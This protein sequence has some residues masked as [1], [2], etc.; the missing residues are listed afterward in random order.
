MDIT[1]K[2]YTDT[3]DIVSPNVDA[4]KIDQSFKDRYQL[5][6]FDVNLVKQ[7]VVTNTGMTDYQCKH[8]VAKSQ[9]TPWKQVRQSLMEL[10]VRYHSYQ[11][12]RASLR[13]SEIT[14]KKML[15]QIEAEADPLDKELIQID[16]EKLD[17]DITIYK[18][19]FLQSEVEIKAFIDVIKQY[20]KDE[21]DLEYYTKDNPEEERNYW[22]ARMGK[23]A[24][25]DIIAFGRVGS[26][27][28]DSIAMMGEEDQL[29]ALTMAVQYS[30]LV[31]AGLHKISNV[32]QS[33]IDQYLNSPSTNIAAVMDAFPKNENIQLTTKPQVNSE[34]I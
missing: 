27:N 24:A 7:A 25:M 20:V 11:E 18:R 5:S 12:I 30:G 9:I 19:K 16:L 33:D 8:F 23:Q 6:D 29:Q 32:T 21:K 26:G 15:R 10:E 17:Y 1:S 28:M 4:I 14:R 13:K 22:I 31:N 3:T 34:T 2:Y